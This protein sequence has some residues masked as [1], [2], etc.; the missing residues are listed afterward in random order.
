MNVSHDLQV[1]REWRLLNERIVEL[2]NAYHL[3][4]DEMM[5]LHVLCR[6]R[7]AI[8]DANTELLRIELERSCKHKRDTVLINW[9][10]EG[11]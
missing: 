2:K 10:Q 3:C 6:K 5:E 4:H 8:F 7:R 11:F 1:L 9:T